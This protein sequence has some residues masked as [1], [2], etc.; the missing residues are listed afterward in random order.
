MRDQSGVD[1]VVALLGVRPDVLGPPPPRDLDELLERLHDPHLVVRAMQAV[2]APT[3]DLAHGLCALGGQAAPDALAT[4]LGTTPATL[5]TPVRWLIERALV[6]PVDGMLVA[7]PGLLAVLGDALGLGPPLRAALERMTAEALRL[8]LRRHGEPRPATKA[9]AVAALHALLGD[10]ERV[11]AVAVTAPERV[12]AW[13]RQQADPSEQDEAFGLSHAGWSTVQDALAWAGDRGLV[14]REPWGGGVVMPRE[15][16][17]ALRGAGYRAPFDPDPPE[18]PAVPVDAATLQRAAAGAVATFAGQATAVLDRLAIRSVPLLRSGGLGAREITKLARAVGVTESTVRLTVELASTLGL[19]E[20]G[21]AT[22]ALCGWRDAE[23]SQR[24]AQLLGAWWAWS[25]VP[26]DD[27]DDGKARPA[28]LGRPCPQCRQG[29]QTLLR[30]VAEAAGAVELADAGIHAVWSRA[31]VH[32]V[33]E[34]DPRPFGRT[35]AEAEALGVIAAGQLGATEARAITP[36]GAAL[37][38]GDEDAVRAQAAAMLPA[39][40]EHVLLSADLTAVAPGTPSSRVTVLLDSCADRESAGGAVTWRFGPASVR[41]AFDDGTTAEALTEA[42]GSVAR[43]G[44]PQP[45]S[46][47]VADVARRHGSLRVAPAAAVVR[48]DDVALLAE[49]AA[50]R[51]LRRLGLELVAP[52]VLT[53]TATP[54]ETLAA[55]RAAGYL[56]V[57]EG[58]WAAPPAGPPEPG[59]ALARAFADVHRRFRP[60]PPSPVDLRALARALLAGQNNRAEEPDD[61]SRVLHE[62]A[63][64]LGAHHV[65]LLARA[66]ADGGAVH[67]SYRS[68]AGVVT[69]RQVSDLQLTGSTV[70]GWCELRQDERVFAVRGIQSVRTVGRTPR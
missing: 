18:V 58:S 66:I 35:W 68:T 12:R 70:E 28:L 37:L 20:A 69:H 2:P 11:R 27:R 16:R 54:T 3:L 44:L 47:L 26:T 62:L 23:P 10:P 48:S 53:A 42:L 51:T 60:A 41:R 19:L 7:S 32:A 46:Y 49:A 33:A 43:N 61:V 56:P 21:E 52:T 59:R 34:S 40:T 50:D 8:V 22:P 65:R 14:L 4:L 57:P 25:G 67:I 45:L 24:Y 64:R 1:G 6:Q 17:L 38:A 29:R 63:P 39:A 31:L 9:D 5:Q 15:V 13:L 55:L 36:L 30:V